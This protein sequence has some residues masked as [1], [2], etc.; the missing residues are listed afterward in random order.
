MYGMLCNPQAFCLSMQ[1]FNK[2]S[3]FSGEDEALLADMA[4]CVGPALSHCAQ[5]QHNTQALEAAARERNAEVADLNAKLE[6]QAEATAELREEMIGLEEEAA[7]AVERVAR[8]ES[9]LR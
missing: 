4:R 3:G 7:A 5:H 6:A 8:A 1:A 2:P 9:C